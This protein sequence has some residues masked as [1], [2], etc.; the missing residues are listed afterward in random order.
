MFRYVSYA[1]FKPSVTLASIL[2][3]LAGWILMRAAVLMLSSVPLQ[4]GFSI[5]G[6]AVE[7]L[8]LVLLARAHVPARK[9]R[10]G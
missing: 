2:L 1:V 4:T 10:N 3:I 6:F 5:A 9:K 8:G 7:M